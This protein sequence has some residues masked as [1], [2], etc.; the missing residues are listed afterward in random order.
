MGAAI[1]FAPMIIG[2][3][4]GALIDRQNP[5]RGAMLGAVG[6]HVATPAVTALMGSGAAAAT[7]G[8]ASMASM[9]PQVAAGGLPS[10][11]SV[12]GQMP[13]ASSLPSMM[14]GGADFAAGA[15]SAASAYNA[16]PV[17]DRLGALMGGM[18]KSKMAMKAGQGL[19]NMGSQQ[20]PPPMASAP[21]APRQ[22]LPPQPM[23]PFRAGVMPQRR[24]SRIIDPFGRSI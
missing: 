13:G 18:D 1:P 10:M 9:A 23:S 11:A 14:A 2:A 24:Q 12:V 15:G 22:A 8:A 19:L 20:Q 17:M 4:A 16:M 3:G 21:S 6:G 7:G 5:L